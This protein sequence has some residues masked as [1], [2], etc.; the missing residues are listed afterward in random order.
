MLRTRSLMLLADANHAQDEAKIDGH[1]LLHRQ[2]VERG[3]VNLPFQPV[4]GHFAA[5]HQIA[6][7]QIAH[8]IGLDGALDRLLGQACHHK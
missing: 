6:D 4:D 3:L 5:A 7:R 2:Q 8:A 1:W